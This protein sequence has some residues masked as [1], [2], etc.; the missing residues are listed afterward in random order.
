[1][2]SY[3]CFSRLR[4]SLVLRLLVKDLP[5][6]VDGWLRGEPDGD[7]GLDEPTFPPSFCYACSFHLTSI[8]SHPVSEHFSPNE[9]CLP[10]R[11]K[12]FGIY[13]RFRTEFWRE[14]ITDSLFFR[15]W[16]PTDIFLMKLLWF[17][18]Y[19]PSFRFFVSFCNLCR[20]CAVFDF[21]FGFTDMLL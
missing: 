18:L 19:T 4:W 3:A 5:V 17:F 10:P 9:L 13:S 15:P 7:S 1:V 6:T 11:P 20:S 12:S 16:L 14:D 21:V 2:E 8:M